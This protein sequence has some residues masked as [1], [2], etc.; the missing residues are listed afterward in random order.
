[1]NNKLVLSPDHVTKL[2]LDKPKVDLNVTQKG[3]TLTVNR[4]VGSAGTPGLIYSLGRDK[5]P[6]VVDVVDPA[7]PAKVLIGRKNMEYG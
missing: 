3:R 7:D 6:L 5:E 2:I 1:M 4:V